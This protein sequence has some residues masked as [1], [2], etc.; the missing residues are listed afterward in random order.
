VG[1][2]GGNGMNDHIFAATLRTMATLSY[3]HHNLLK[4]GARGYNIED[5]ISKVETM[6]HK[7]IEF[8]SEQE[9]QVT[10]QKTLPLNFDEIPF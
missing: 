5:S 3:I 2:E 1:G 9:G 6:L 7:G 4:S 8:L 10:S